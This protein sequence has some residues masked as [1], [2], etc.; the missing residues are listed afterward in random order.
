MGWRTLNRSQKWFLLIVVACASYATGNAIYLAQASPSIDIAKGYHVIYIVPHE[1]FDPYWLDPWH[2]EVERWCTNFRDA[3]DIMRVNP[4]MCY[5]VDQVVA[6]KYFWEN[7]PDYHDIIKSLIAEGRLE[8]VQ[9]FVSQPD[10]NLV[11]E[12][13]LIEDAVLGMKWAESVL[14]ANITTGWEL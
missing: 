11:S 8:V 7:Y 14:G 4:Q 12:E 13:G 10:E 3:L 2:T 6:I 9:G 5:V 1:H